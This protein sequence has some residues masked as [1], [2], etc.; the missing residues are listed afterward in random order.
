MQITIQNR[1]YTLKILYGTFPQSPDVKNYQLPI[2]M[3]D[4]YFQFLLLLHFTNA[5]H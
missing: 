1:V 5:L 3:L 2:Y 4:A